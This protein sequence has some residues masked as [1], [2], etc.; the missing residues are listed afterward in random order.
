MEWS[1]INGT[2]LG[3]LTSAAMEDSRFEKKTH[4]KFVLR[5]INHPDNP[6]KQNLVINACI[7]SNLISLRV[8]QIHGYMI[9]RIT[10]LTL[11]SWSV[12]IGYSTKLRFSRCAP[13]THRLAP[14]GKLW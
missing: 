2:G 8:R 4:F 6:S 10:P 9:D 14:T 3:F 13:F 12:S 1:R 7:T 11:S 5:L